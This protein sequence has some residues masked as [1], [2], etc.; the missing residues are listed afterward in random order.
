MFDCLLEVGMEE[1]PA[2][3][4][5]ALM[6]QSGAKMRELLDKHGIPFSLVETHATPRR[7]A[8]CAYGLSTLQL[9]REVEVV[10][11]PAAA[12]YDKEGFPTK[13]CLGFARG[14]GVQPD[15]VYTIQ[16]SKGAYIAATKR[17]GGGSTKEILPGILSEVL[18]SLSF[19]KKM[20]WSGDG[21]AF[22]RPIRWLVAL[23]DEE[24]LPLRVADVVSDRMTHGHRVMGPGPWAVARA[25]DYQ[26]VLSEKAWVVLDP[27]ERKRRIITRGDELAAARRG[28][29]LWL[30][31]LLE[32]VVNLV[33]FPL[34][35]LGNFDPEFL[36]L[37]EE[38]LLTSL[39]I[40]QKSFGV[41][42]EDGRLLPLFLTV[43]NS[44]PED[45]EV[46]RR[47]WQRV[48]KA[49][50]EDAK[51]FWK[52]DCSKR[53]DQWLESLESV[54]F[55]GPLGSMAD[56]ARR[57]ESLA[58]RIALAVAP[59]KAPLAGRAGL[60]CK[61]DLVSEMVGEF[62]DLQ[63]IMGGIYAERLNEEAEVCRGIYE[64]Y[65]PQGQDSPTPKSVL[66]AL[67]SIA[68]KAD[69]MSACFGLGMAPT[70]AQD[71]HGMRRQ[72]LGICRTLLAHDFRL[73]L[74]DVFNLA[75]ANYG[76]AR[77]TEDPESVPET[78]LGFI[79]QRLRVYFQAEGYPTRLIDAVLKADFRDVKGAQLRLQALERFSR[80]EDFEEAVLTFKRAANIIVKQAGETP[81]DGFWDPGLLTEGPETVLAERIAQLAPRFEALRVEEAYDRLFDMLR[82]LRPDVDGFFDSVMVMCD[83]PALRLNRLNILAALVAMLSPLADFSQL[84]V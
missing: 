63:G 2:R 27:A 61:C 55:I 12:A 66:G 77:W 16:T 52:A 13:A 70:G 6:E 64:H 5:P 51:F 31:G 79:G 37:P 38:V 34:P 22:G 46:V 36:E 60:L 80:S 44:E 56:K 19:P 23:L 32:H 25:A 71:P 57:L 14:Q 10:G 81:P 59:E 20:R 29:V 76:Q 7:L 78:I 40:H 73:D 15:E 41:R 67:L 17:E 68:D 21:F 33:E 9:S 11:P 3:F 45:V 4:I 54:Q 74:G 8:V 62:D 42:G 43:I 35:L 75:V 30:E 69:T 65:L 28:D 84:Q 83:D 39:E 58:C 49:R 24:V 50:L 82:S 48:L 47:G 53:F 18:H 1:M 72:A 26:V